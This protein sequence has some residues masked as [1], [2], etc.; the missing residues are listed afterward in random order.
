MK[1]RRRYINRDRESV[2][3][4]LHQDYFTDDYVYPS[5]YFRRRYH[6]R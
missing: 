4:R 2:H 3:D 6:M 5:N 1:S